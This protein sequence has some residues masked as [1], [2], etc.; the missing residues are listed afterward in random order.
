MKRL[1]GF[2]LDMRVEKLQ[3][4]LVKH[5]ARCCVGVESHCPTWAALS[6]QYDDALTRRGPR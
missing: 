5:G 1:L 4:E 2:L 6:I 3:R